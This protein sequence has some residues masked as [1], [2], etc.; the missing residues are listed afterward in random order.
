MIVPV[1]LALMR[2]E[3]QG[4]ASQRLGLCP[5]KPFLCSLYRE[6]KGKQ[7]VLVHFLFNSR[8]VRFSLADIR[9]AYSNVKVILS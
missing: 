7:A 3:S 6:G 2:L 4:K 9:S 8:P 5:R 1:L